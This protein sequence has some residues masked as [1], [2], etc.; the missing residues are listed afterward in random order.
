VVLECADDTP[1]SGEVQPLLL[2]LVDR[3]I[4]GS[5]PP[6]TPSR[7]ATSSWGSGVL[8]R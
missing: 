5:S 1:G 2:E 7:E 6:S 3:G 8:A 4:L